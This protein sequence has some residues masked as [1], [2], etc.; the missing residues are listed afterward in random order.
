M[1]KIVLILDPPHGKEVPGKRSPD[2]R[3]EEWKWGRE[4][5]K[6]IEIIAKSLGF[7]VEWTTKG[8][9][10]I[11]LSKRVQIAENIK[12]E[13]GQIKLLV[14]LHNNAAGDGTQWV[15]AT[16]FEVWTNTSVDKA[17]EYADLL[18]PIYKKWFPKVRLRINKNKA[19]EQDKEKN[20]T[21]LTGKTYF[22]LLL[23]HLFQD[24][25][26][27]V[28]MLLNSGESKKFEDFFIDWIEMIEEF[29]SSKG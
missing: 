12:V 25:K 22:G 9:T 27:D 18:F 4:R 26:E 29:E 16:G 28:E 23:E 13:K 2:G 14:S 19:S 3:H 15:S 8:D 5:L 21:V 17:D 11:G 24:N 6:Q 7:R 20:F 1:K 10:E